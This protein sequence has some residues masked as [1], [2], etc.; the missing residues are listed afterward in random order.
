MVLK[1]FDKLN[2]VGGVVCPSEDEK[3]KNLFKLLN[4][5]IESRKEKLMSAGVSSFAAYKEAGEK[6]L[7][8][9]V[10]LIDNL[11]ALKELYFQ[12]DGELLNL[13]RE[14]LTVGISIVIANSQTA[15]I[16]YKYLSNFSARMALYCNDSNEYSSLFDHCSERI[17][18]IPGRSI[19]EIDK[20]HYECQSYLAFKGEKEIDRLQDIK[21]YIS[22]TN[23]AN[24][25]MMAKRI[26]LI[27]ASLTKGFMVEQFS[28]YMEDK[29][30]IVTGLDYA[31]VTPYVLDFASAGLLA[32]AGREGAG[33]HNWLKYSV[34]MLS[35]MYPGMSKVYVV[36]SIGK[37]LASLKESD[38]ITAYSMI[39]DDAVKYIK[40]IEMQLKDRYDSLVAGNEDVLNDA[41]LL[42][43][44]IDNQDALLAICNNS[45]ALAAYKNIIGRYKNMKVCITVFVENANIPYSAPEIMKNIRDQRNFMYFDDMSNMKIFDVPL[46][47]S[48]NFKK[49]IEQGDCYYIRDNECVKLKTPASGKQIA[50]L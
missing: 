39:A 23:A 4:T 33:R 18:S 14:G 50:I 3:L 48:R 40:E 2:H 21:K 45:D 10:L 19:V 27:P 30:S 47:M 49:P 25:H 12:D 38:N 20:G 7:P 42:M 37:K 34:D 1:N 28:N 43:L 36:D 17:D 6:D 29:F 24:K 35:T 9:I 22:E 31:T 13:C 46:A 5:E 32:I 8:L 26:P 44:V 41:E 15:G 16:G 11:T